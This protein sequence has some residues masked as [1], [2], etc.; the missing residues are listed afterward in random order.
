MFE[1]IEELKLYLKS[2]PDEI[3]NIDTK[4]AKRDFFY[5]VKSYLP[6]HIEF[7]KTEKSKFR[8][9]IYKNIDSLT[10]K[11]KFLMFSAYRGAAKTTLIATFY[12]LWEAIRKKRRFILIIGATQ[13][14]AN[15]T[16]ELLKTELIENKKLRRDFNIEIIQE[17]TESIVIKVDDFNLKIAAFGAGAKIRGIKYLSFRPDLIIV[18]DLEED[19]LVQNK[20]Y[21]DKQ[22]KW[23]KKAIK[24]LP[25]RK[26]KHC[27][28]IMI[29][30]ILH[31]D[32]VFVRLREIADFYQNFPLVLDFKTWKLDDPDID[33]EELK[34]EYKEDKESF[35]QEYQNI[36]LSKDSLIFNHYK[37]FEI[38][39][40]CD[41]Y[42]IGI[43]PAMGK[44][45][46]DYFAIAILGYKADE[47]RFYL[48]AHGYKKNPTDMIDKIVKTYIRYSKV[49]RTILAIETVAY[50]EFFKDVLKK[51]ARES[52]VSIPVK[53]FKNNVPKE[54]RINSLAPLIKDETILID[55]KAELLRDELDTY[56]KSAHDDLLDASEM[57]K[58]AFESGGGVDYRLVRKHLKNFSFK[59]LKYGF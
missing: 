43:D 27:N 34:K 16:F 57:A 1:N 41:F 59:G 23:F 24:K 35:L 5:F 45:K 28:I 49:A 21:R 18:D 52:G 44:K 3:S 9:F 55:E 17:K 39:P 38:M 14:L 54:L 2:L 26:C 7:A 11:H 37:T 8:N 32:S 56:P 58:R 19:E 4:R 22:E 47:K 33:V 29:G 31:H 12:P 50:Q 30:T 13:P 20:S 51:V 6:H 25:S 42:S 40:K 10:K 36:P 15:A 53:E 46:G 48:T